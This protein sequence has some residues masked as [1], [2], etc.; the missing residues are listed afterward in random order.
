MMKNISYLYVSLSVILWGSTAAVAK[1][2][3]RDMSS[4]QILFY[5][6][7]ISAVSLFVIIL[8]QKKLQL[9]KTY[10][11]SDY[12]KFMYMGFLGIFLY[13]I[14]LFQGLTYAPA[15]EAFIVNYTWPIWVIIFAILILKEKIGLRKIVAI[16]LGFIG[17]YFVATK[18][19][20]IG[21]ENL[22]GD[23]FALAGAVAYGLFSVLTKKHNYEK[24]TSM[25]FYN[26]FTFIFIAITS[27]FFFE[28]PTIESQQVLGL[29]WLGVMTSSLAHIF[30]FLAL[31]HGDTAKMSGI[32]YLTP[33]V[34][35]VYIFILLKESILISSVTGLIIIV[36]GILLQSNIFKKKQVL[37]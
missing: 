28:V 3:L 33:F 12:W 15:Q 14:F 7:L 30:W 17:V 37:D 35:L 36:A 5:T 13:Y 19:E 2:L 1:L 16:L 23:L 8:F 25:M 9:I 26:I 18:G 27:I 21:I 20:F 34:S 22:R 31:K 29:L 24:F 32:I 4:L 11:K 10:T 6:S